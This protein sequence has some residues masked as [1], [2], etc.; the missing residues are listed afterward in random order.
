VNTFYAFLPEN[1]LITNL[2]QGQIYPARILARSAVFIKRSFNMNGTPG[3][4]QLDI[5]ATRLLLDLESSNHV[6]LLLRVSDK[7]TR[8]ELATLTLCIQ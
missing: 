6:I 5:S 2:L 8:L 4:Y 1:S 3:F 7:T